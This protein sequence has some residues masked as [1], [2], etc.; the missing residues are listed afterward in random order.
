MLMNITWAGS[1]IYPM[2][3]RYDQPQLFI[4]NPLILIPNLGGGEQ[5]PQGIR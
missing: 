3:L 2:N 1:R 4:V 5:G